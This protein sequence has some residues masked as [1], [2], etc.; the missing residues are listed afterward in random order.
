[1]D[2]A[3]QYI[4]TVCSKLI[5]DQSL[6]ES[7]K[8]EF[9]THIETTL[10]ELVDEGMNEG[11]SLELAL[12]RIGDAE[13]LRDALYSV[14]RRQPWTRVLIGVCAVVLG[15]FLMH[16]VYVFC[17]NRL[18]HYGIP[19]V[20]SIQIKPMPDE[21]WIKFHLIAH[22]GEWIYS[23]DIPFAKSF[24]RLSYR[25][26]QGELRSVLRY[27]AD[28]NERITA[29]LEF[30]RNLREWVK[31]MG[32]GE[33][34]QQLSE[35]ME[36][37][38]DA[39]VRL[40][41]TIALA[42]A[43]LARPIGVLLNGLKHER[44]EIRAGAAEAL[45][46]IDFYDERIV[47]ALLDT[48]SNDCPDVQVAAFKSLRRL[49][50]NDEDFIIALKQWQSDTNKRLRDSAQDALRWLKASRSSI[51]GYSIDGGKTCVPITE[52]TPISLGAHYIKHIYPLGEVKEG[53]SAFVQPTPVEQTCIDA[54]F[55]TIPWYAR[56]T[57]ALSK[58]MIANY[59]VAPVVT[60]AI[61]AVF[62]FVLCI[63]MGR[64]WRNWIIFGFVFS[65]SLL[66]HILPC[67]DPESWFFYPKGIA[68]LLTVYAFCVLGILATVFMIWYAKRRVSIVP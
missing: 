47:R 9:Q 10:E 62:A 44:L 67:L 63:K 21:V 59:I 23:P 31:Y 15:V 48:L 60:F 61:F 37:D 26:S 28:S 4:N 36:N 8:K 32:V 55:A 24:R 27:S 66:W 16:R 65:P 38:A 41:A 2:K 52:L 33:S 56:Y 54:Y 18:K 19:Y 50:S 58:F 64:R 42:N 14:H 29:A 17:L 13:M 51:I 22:P 43:E 46:K 53:S 25:Q 49:A 40:A 6:R 3:E 1:M 5:F 57:L 68:F 12:Q 11:E 35:I 30:G 20:S 7:V 34:V 45:G 39:D